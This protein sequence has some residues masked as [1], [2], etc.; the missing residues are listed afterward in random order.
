MAAPSLVVRSSTDELAFTG[1]EL[2]LSPPATL[3]TFLHRWWQ[4]RLEQLP[5]WAELVART[6]EARDGFIDAAQGT[7]L[8]ALFAHQESS[9][10]LTPT[11]GWSGGTGVAALNEW[12][13]AMLMQA[14]GRA[15][16]RGSA[17]DAD[18]PLVGEPVLVM[19]NDYRRNLYNG[20]QGI[21]LAVAAE[22]GAPALMAVLR[23]S[24]ASGGAGAF[25][26]VP[27]GALRAHLEPAWASTVHKA[28][29]SEHDSVALIMPTAETR[30]L[31]RELLYTAVTR[32]R[33]SVV[34]IGTSERLDQAIARAV[35]R[36]SGI[37]E[38]LA[39]DKPRPAA[40]AATAKAA[41][42]QQLA[43]PFP[44]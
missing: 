21:V 7:D 8:E 26:A 11:R 23:A 40:A 2:L 32:A 3:S 29:G 16:M 4:R 9:R 41:P 12:F 35:E 10:L 31:T 17:R 30:L 28:Q 36:W 5:R 20:D 39:P 19:R 6:W 14:L 38:A 44:D 43:L 24:G 15:S 25:R 33:R 37:A 34:V 42:R 13:R 22:G 18:Q 27:L 1:A